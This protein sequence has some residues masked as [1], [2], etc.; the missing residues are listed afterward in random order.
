MKKQLLFIF[1]LCL[2]LLAQAQDFRMLE[3]RGL[4]AITLD[5]SQDGNLLA[6]G[7]GGGQ[8][9]VWDVPRGEVLTEMDGHED[10]VLDVA[11]SPDAYY[12]ASASADNSIHVWNVTQGFLEKRFTGHTAE[13][14]SLAF[15]LDGKYLFSGSADHSISVWD[16]NKNMKL[17][18]LRGHREAVSSLAI[19]PAGDKVASGSYDGKVKIWDVKTFSE[20]ASIDIKGKQIR[21]LDFSLDGKSLVVSTDDKAVRVLDMETLTPTLLMLGHKD[22]A[23]DVDFSADGKWIFSAGLD[24]KIIVWDAETGMQHKEYPKVGKNGLVVMSASSQGDYLAV[25]NFTD[26]IKLYKT[27]YLDIKPAKSRVMAQ[28][29]KKAQP[30]YTKPTKTVLVHDKT[31]P[32]VTI[33]QPATESGKPFLWL[34][35]DLTVKGQ[36]SSKNGLYELTINKQEV[37]VDEN[38]RF[39]FPLKLAFGNNT[40]EVKAVDIFNNVTTQTF[41]VQRQLK[42]DEYND[43][44]ARF[45]KDYALIICTDEYDNYNNLS[46]PVFDGESI[47][48]ELKDNFG[49]EVE[50]IKNPS[51]LEIYQALRAY[52]KRQYSD[53]DQLFIFIAGHGEFDEVFHE[54]YLVPKDAQDNDEVR[55]SLISHSNLK[56]IVNNIPCKHIFLTM[57]ACFGG[58]LG[59]N[60]DRQNRVIATRRT[61]SEQASFIQKRLEPTTRQFLTSGGQQYVPDGI[62]GHHS[63]FASKFIE[64][65]QAGAGK[66]DIL[67]L[68][69]LYSYLE[70]VKPHPN[71]GTFG[72]NQHGSD[73]L[74][75]RQNQEAQVGSN[76][77]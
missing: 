57:D 34:E 27:G 30:D 72:R 11:F 35:K 29:H 58:T 65:L 2:S 47:G 6:V 77:H 14:T 59:Y 46:N 26:K 3:A 42:I 60:I 63:P 74:F 19:T 13:V 44:T 31:A 8:V 1:S 68:D 10:M 28:T 36:C 25:A 56:T 24:N 48:Q 22:V 73:F 12:V 32:Q 37:L 52:G 49:F 75:I 51:R 7:G 39:D 43:T 71:S 38:G 21:A 5:F 4:D 69:E 9:I 45:G 40:V 16:L 18:E 67:V 33:V 66:D 55:A 62:A 53:D 15:S 54:G 41:V 17:T 23:Y 70:G 61:S 20:F 50:V 64:S 76:E